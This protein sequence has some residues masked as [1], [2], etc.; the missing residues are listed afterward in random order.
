MPSSS[1]SRRFIGLLIIPG[2]DGRPVTFH[3]DLFTS[4]YANQAALF[5]ASEDFLHIEQDH[6]AL[7]VTDFADARDEL[8]V[9]AGR[10][11][12]RRRRN[13]LGGDVQ[14]LAD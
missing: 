13:V 7:P 9:D 12:R 2:G 11:G 14:H 1:L 3:S 5:F 10:D 8:V 6:H 4:G